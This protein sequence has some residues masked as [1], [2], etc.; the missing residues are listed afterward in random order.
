MNHGEGP[1][2]FVG[3]WGTRGS[4]QIGDGEG[5]PERQGLEDQRRVRG[6]VFGSV[7]GDGYLGAYKN[8][9]RNLCTSLTGP[10]GV[11]RDG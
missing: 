9:T 4:M 2:K 8:G 6:L 5:T 7:R 1:P 3:M 11:L 10:R